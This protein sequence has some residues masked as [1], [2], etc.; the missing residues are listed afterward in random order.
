[1]TLSALGQN[2]KTDI[3]S[4]FS[5]WEK[6][7]HPGGVVYIAHKNQV[8]FAQAYGLA[9][10]QYQVPNNLE[11]LFD[12][13]SLSKQ[14]TAMGIVLLQQQGKLSLD[15]EI[16][17]YLPELHQFKKTITI[18]HLLHHTA[19]LRSSP[20]FFSLAGWREGDGISNEDFYRYMTQ[21]VDLNFEPGTEYM[22]SNSG[23]ILLAKII[24]NISQQDFKSWMKEKIFQPLD[25][26]ATFVEEDNT[27]IIPKAA[28]SYTEVAPDTFRTTENYDLTYGASN[29]YTTS[30]DVLKWSQN[31]NKTSPEWQKAF[32]MLQTLDPLRS[33][34]KNNY[35][36]G[37]F[38][39]ELYGHPRIQHSGAVGGF[40]SVMYVYPDENLQIVILA[41]GNPNPI[42]KMA[43]QISQYFLEDK[44]KPQ[45]PQ[46]PVNPIALK[47]DELKRY[48]GT[49]W[50]DKT[51]YARKIFLDNDTLWYIRSNQ[52]KS[53][54]IPVAENEFVIGGINEKMVLKFDLKSGTFRLTSGNG[55]VDLFE[56]Y[57]DQPLTAEELKDYTGTF[58]SPELESTYTLSLKDGKLY[59]YHSKFGEAEVQVLKKDVLDWSGSAISKYRRD[60]NQK[61]KG[62]DVSVNR[63]KNLWFEKK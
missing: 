33:G 35:A 28:T 7:N 18:R 24:E 61:I 42:F 56:K 53:P 38:I 10:L 47:A 52:K 39:D 26:K 25:M 40:L 8:V 14:F 55:S 2:L 31:F 16:Q 37:L 5:S 21:Q 15:D 19:G 13:G 59:V 57:N 44:S 20:E 36:L 50:N 41:N 4:L 54:L 11:T 23:Y 49:Y 9:N 60:K 32:A 3:G 27:Q 12:I 43:D 30:A 17:N 58:Y 45:V 48:E 46:A 62:F 63:V 51:N 6:P 1:M 29:I 34:A 22:Y